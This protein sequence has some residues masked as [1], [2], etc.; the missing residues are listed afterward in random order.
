MGGSILDGM[1]EEEAPAG[2]GVWLRE[3]ASDAMAMLSRNQSR[4]VG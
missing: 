3:E 4:E 2:G 1:V